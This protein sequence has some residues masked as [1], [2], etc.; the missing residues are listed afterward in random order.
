MTKELETRLLVVTSEK[1][2]SVHCNYEDSEEGSDIDEEESPSSWHDMDDKLQEL[3][4]SFYPGDDNFLEYIYLIDLDCELFSINDCIA[5]DLWAIPP[6]DRLVDAFA[7]GAFDPDNCPQGSSR[8][9]PPSYFPDADHERNMWTNTYRQYAVTRV[10][11]IRLNEPLHKAPLYRVFAR[12]VFDKLLQPRSVYFGHLPEMGHDS[13]AFREIA[14]VILSLAAGKFYFDRLANFSGGSHPEDANGFLM[15]IG[16]EDE[17]KLMPIF[18]SGCHAEDQE[19]GPAPLEPLYWFED[20]L[21]SLVPNTV[22][23]TDSDAEAAIGKVVAYV[24]ESGKL[25]FQVVLFSIQNAVLVEVQTQSVTKTI[26]R[27]GVIPVWR[28]NGWHNDT[29]SERNE[30]DLTLSPWDHLQHKYRGFTALEA[31]FDVACVRQLSASG[32][33]RLPVEL[34]PEILKHCVPQT[35]QACA[36]VSPLWRT[37]CHERFAFSP[38]LM[39]VSLDNSG[40]P[41]LPRKRSV[42]LSDGIGI[43]SFQDTKSGSIIQSTLETDMRLKINRRKE[44][45]SWSPVFGDST[46]PSIM[47]QVTLRMLLRHD[48]GEVWD[49]DPRHL[50]SSRDSGLM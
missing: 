36:R 41:L 46:R 6:I 48:D 5:F 10:E 12:V 3:P 43:V 8:I 16:E 1:M 21:I 17:P 28:K 38:D 2:R 20:V 29:V 26:R 27:S 32:H 7:W 4:T 42:P 13:F 44:V 45:S 22:F 14:F 34:Y 33:R 18:G 37:L 49:I 15:S 19:P 25:N 39:A 9:G 31:F 11:P 40:R 35:H 30:R 47:T 23:E 24:L 50:E